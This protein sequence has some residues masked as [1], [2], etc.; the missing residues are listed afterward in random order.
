M[1]MISAENRGLRLVTRYAVLVLIAV[2][3]IF[4]LVFMLMSSLKPDQQLLQRI[5]H[6][7]P[8][9]DHLAAMQQLVGAAAEIA[10]AT[11]C[12][13]HQQGARGNVP[14]LHAGL[15]VGI[16]ATGRDI[17]VKIDENGLRFEEGADGV[18]IVLRAFGANRLMPEPTDAALVT[19]TQ[20]VG[21]L[22]DPRFELVDTDVVLV[23]EGADGSTL[24]ARR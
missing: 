18:D 2:I 11:A 9:C 12:L 5:D 15:E 3:F 8:A 17:V 13:A 22:F 10:A 14:Q 6:L 20:E 24:S 19:R 1:A 23:I 4:P 7:Q 16:G 21:N